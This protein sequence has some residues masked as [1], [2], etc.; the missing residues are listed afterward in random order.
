[1]ARRLHLLAIL[2]CFGFIFYSF[3]GQ[4]EAIKSESENFK[5]DEELTRIRMVQMAREL[6]V[7]CAECHSPKNWKDDSKANFKIARDHIK[8]VEVLKNVGYDGKKYPEA[9]C[10][11][12]HQGH[13]NFASRMQHPETT[14]KSEE[15]K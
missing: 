7:T 11:M 13:L 4:S 15:K 2:V 9:S 1:M 5:K 12:C 8:T 10:Y 6:G 3:A 14:I